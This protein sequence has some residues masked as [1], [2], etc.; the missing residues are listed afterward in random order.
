MEQ[1]LNYFEN[2]GLAMQLALPADKACN[3]CGSHLNI[4]DV[5]NNNQLVWIACPNCVVSNDNAHDFYSLPLE[6]VGLQ[7]Q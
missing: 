2:Y 4:V 1:L 3:F 6:A 5:D 7:Q